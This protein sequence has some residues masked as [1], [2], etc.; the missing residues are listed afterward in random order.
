MRSAFA[1]EHL[2][3]MDGDILLDVLRSRMW[4]SLDHLFVR[5]QA[6]IGVSEAV[7]A[8]FGSCPVAD[9]SLTAGDRPLA[10]CQ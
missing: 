3:L 1:A 8:H 4:T 10:D 2:L 5:G 7:N 9:H 6:G